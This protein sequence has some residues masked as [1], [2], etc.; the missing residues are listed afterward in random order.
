MWSNLNY[1]ASISQEG[2][3]KTSTE[4]NI[5]SAGHDLSLFLQSI[6]YLTVTLLSTR[7][8]YL[9]TMLVAV[10]MSLPPYILRARF[11]SGRTF[12]FL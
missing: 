3:R 12:H 2:T 6:N 11:S 1:Y 4:Y 10:E 8:L 9:N 5:Q 7:Q